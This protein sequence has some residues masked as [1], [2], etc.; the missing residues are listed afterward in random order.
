MEGL[1]ALEVIEKMV[2]TEDPVD[3]AVF[4]KMVETDAETFDS[5]IKA[6]YPSAIGVTEKEGDN[7]MVI[8][9]HEEK[10]HVGT[11]VITRKI[12][13]FGGSRVGS[14]NPFRKPGDPD[15]ENP[16]CFENL[17]RLS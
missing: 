11:Y 5:F 13:Y 3:G 16:F 12:G 1:E 15:V 6:C 9:N 10:G 8:Y 4:E 7:F 14:K 2:D 17:G